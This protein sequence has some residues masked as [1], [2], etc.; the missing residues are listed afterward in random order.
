MS[1]QDMDQ[2]WIGGLSVD[3][4]RHKLRGALNELVLVE[5]TL[6][7]A[8]GYLRSDGGPDDPNGGGYVTGEHTAVSLATEAG[9]A[10]AR[11][12]ASRRDWAAEAA[13]MDALAE[14]ML[15]FHGQNEERLSFI[16]RRYLS[17]AGHRDRFTGVSSDALAWY[18]IGRRDEPK[19]G[20]Y[21]AD[22][23]DL[24]AC[25]RTYE[26]APEFLKER[27]LPVL[28]RYR[29]HVRSLPLCAVHPE[30]DR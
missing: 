11:V 7:G 21:P 15:T 12:E 17:P 9:N 6:A 14:R 26:M 10:L 18:A 29:A 3:D 27:M 1:Q 24:A 4:L 16:A 20:E 5:D 30:A 13:A 28:E 23:Q 19:P 8:L 2:D 22:E 25:E